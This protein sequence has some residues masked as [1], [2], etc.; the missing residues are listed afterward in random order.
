[1][2]YFCTAVLFLL[3]LVLFSQN[4]TEIRTALHNVYVAPNYSKLPP[5]KPGFIGE[6]SFGEK[7]NGEEYWHYYYGYPTFYFSCFAGYPG[8]LEYGY[9]IGFAPQ[10]SFDKRIKNRWNYHIKTGLGIAYHT[11]PYDRKYNPNNML[12]GSNFTALAN[13][14]I[15]VSYEFQPY[16]HIGIAAG[17]LHFSNGHCKLP[18]IG[19]N[20]PTVNLFYRY[21]YSDPPEDVDYKYRDRPDQEWK[22]FVN[23][24]L[25]MHEFGTSTKPANGPNYQVYDIGFGI[26]KKTSPIHKFRLG[27]NMLQYDSFEKFIIYQELDIGDPF[28]KSSVLGVFGAH[29]FLF[30]DFA[31]YT[32][33]GLDIYKPFY[34]YMVTMN[35]DKFTVKDILKSINSNKLGLRYYFIKSYDYAIIGGVNLKVNMAQA[36]F[37]EI[38]CSFEF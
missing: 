5:T 12:I 10:F 21:S 23:L 26:C 8:A 3:S 38:I 15:G 9:V 31:L 28:L 13:A 20:L 6:M 32:E 30:G 16:S 34:R 35:G 4:S 33:L 11:N 18:N 19:M 37:V 25:G 22:I 27:V 1:M 29:E 2:K 7:L 36:D 24:G 14:E 17:A